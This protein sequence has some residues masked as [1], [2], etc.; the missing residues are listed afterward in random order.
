L[1]ITVLE[2]LA[3]QAEGKLPAALNAMADALSQSRTEGYVRLFLDEGPAMINLLR[4]A[5]KAGIMPDYATQLLTSFPIKPIIAQTQPLPEF[6][7]TRELDV[8][9]LMVSGYSNPEIAR[10]L[11]VS[12][13]TIKT[14][15]SHIYSKLNVRNRA[16][17]VK[18]AIDLK[19]I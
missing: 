12:V 1:E 15:T 4:Q 18:R 2:A 7:S 6:L 9:R 19:L 17:A 13:G 10:E 3:F 5:V 11:V 8:L 16:E 14:H